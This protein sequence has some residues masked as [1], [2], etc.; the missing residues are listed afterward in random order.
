M[1]RETRHLWVGNLPENV[2][3]EKIIEHFKRC[4][5]VESV[6]ILPKRGSEGGVAAFVDIKSAQK[7]HNSVNKMGDRDLRT[8]YNEPGT[9]PSAARGLDDTVSIASRSREVS[10][11]RGG[12]GGPAYGPPPSL[13]AREGRYERR[14]DGASD[15]MEHAYEHSAY[16]HHEWGTGAFDRTRH[17]DQD[18]YRDPREGTLQHG[19]YYTSRSRSPNCF[20][21]HDPGYEPRVRE[22]FTLPSVVHRDIY[23][24]DITREVRG[25]RPE[26]NYQHSR[27]RSPHSSQ[28][29]NQSP[30]RLASEASRPTRSP[31]GS[32][33]RSR[34]SSSDS[35]SS[36]SS[37]SS[38]SSDS[39]SSSSDDSPARSVQSAA[40]PAPTSQLLSSLEKDEPRKS[41]GINVQNL[42]VR[43][44]DTSLKDGLF[45]EFKKFGKVTSVQIHGASEERYG[46]VFFR[47]QEDQEKALTASKGKLFFGMQI[48][49]TAWIGPETESENEFC[50][51]DERI[52]EFHPKA[53]RTLFIGNLEKTTTYHDLRNIFQRF[54]EIV[55]IDIKKVNGVPQYAFLQYC[56][57]ASVSKAIKKMDGGSTLEIIASSWVLERA[58]L[59]TACGWMGFL[60][61]CRIN[62]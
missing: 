62:I 47:Q 33:S 12:G 24:D 16:G 54:G 27:S 8:D 50:P 31:S 58:C 44:T 53:T 41:F 25:R 28:S 40:V 22:Q 60:Q 34:S 55:D 1:V 29:R 35:I 45:H 17:Y 49:V 46:L 6:K 42:P 38:D 9:I 4:G 48:E 21:A 14:L 43:S 61:M 56:H 5:R 26:R 51:L 32:G 37:T 36:S 57:I 30:Q 39:S 19:L 15:N 52:D 10:G 18:Y 2:G 7:A 11:F 20:D 3:E 23:R 13:H 59:Q